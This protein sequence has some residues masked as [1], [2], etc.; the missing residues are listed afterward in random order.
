MGVMGD[1]G[2]EFPIAG[3]R[4]MASMSP[5]PCNGVVGEEGAEMLALRDFLTTRRGSVGPPDR[6]GLSRKMDAKKSWFSK[7]E[8]ES[9]GDESSRGFASIVGAV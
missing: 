2:G 6:V 8:K 4:N 5:Q 9:R 1:S 7:E 3:P